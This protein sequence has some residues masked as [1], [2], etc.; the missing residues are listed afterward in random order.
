MIKLI[1]P[2]HPFY[3]PLWRRVLI[4]AVCCAWTGLEF[5]NGSQAWGTMFLV[6]ASY[7]FATLILFFKPK[8]PAAETTAPDGTPPA[9]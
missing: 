3:R 8:P 9:A 6:V 4:V 2:D 7:A 5:W 1:D